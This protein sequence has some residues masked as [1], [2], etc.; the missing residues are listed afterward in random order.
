MEI[1]IVEVALAVP[2]IWTGV[3][4][5]VASLILDGTAHNI[6]TVPAKPLI[7]PTVIE[8]V[9]TCP[10]FKEIVPAEIAVSEKSCTVSLTGLD[11]V[12]V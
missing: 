8:V 1:V 7:E 12:P 5:Q 10:G 2:V 4:E 11:V 9:A 3:A 6:E